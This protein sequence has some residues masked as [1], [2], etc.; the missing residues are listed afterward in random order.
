MGLVVTCIYLVRC[1]CD[2]LTKRL[3]SRA[4]NVTSKQIIHYFPQDVVYCDEDEDPELLVDPSEKFEE[5]LA[6]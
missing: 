6:R 2:C 3:I 1:L 5:M 4:I